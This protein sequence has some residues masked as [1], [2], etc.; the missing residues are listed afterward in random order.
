VNIVHSPAELEPG[1]R[2]F[3]LA[4]GVFDGVHLGHQL[5]LRQALA[6]ARQHEALALVVTFDRHPNS[7][8]APDRVPPLICSRPQKLRAI[9]ALGVDALLEIPFDESF[10]R[11]SGEQF[12]RALAGRLGRVRSICVGADF[13]FGHQRSGNVALLRQLG[14]EF[15]FT[16][17]GLEPVTLEGRPVSSTRIREAI[18]AGDFA[19]AGRMLG[20]PYALAG[21]VVHGDRLGRQLGFPTANLDTRG[22]VLPPTGV[23]AA[24]V[25]GAGLPPAQPAV[26]NIGHRPTV[27][28]PATGPRVEVHLLDY[29][30]ELYGRELE[31]TFTA[32]LRG[33]QKFGS[34]PELQQQIQRDVAAARRQS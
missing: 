7:V 20:R 21:T 17:L 14:S 10:S 18:A 29:A 5:I 22:L 23:Y 16:A 34:L 26:L 15:G 1:P 13:V 19:A 32:R 33:E 2:R 27:A 9:A 8:V 31:V 4:I 25:T 11:Q 6:E 3:C 24:R 30:G 12:I 28:A